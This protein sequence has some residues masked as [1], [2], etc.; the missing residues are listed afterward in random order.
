MSTKHPPPPGDQ[1]FEAVGGAAELAGLGLDGLSHA[2]PLAILVGLVAI[3][4]A[5]LL[6]FSRRRAHS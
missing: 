4:V 5:K 1:S 2:G 3:V 6:W